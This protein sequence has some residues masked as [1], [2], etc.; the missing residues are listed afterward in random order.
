MLFNILAILFAIL[1]I[2]LY[3]ISYDDNCTGWYKP[4]LI[5]FFIL[6]L[7]FF[8]SGFNKERDVYT[9]WI[10]PSYILLLC[11]VIV[12]LQTIIN[13][14]LEYGLLHE[15][16]RASGYEAVFGKCLFIGVLSIVGF[17]IGNYNTHY[18]W[19]T[20]HR[21]ESKNT[22]QW[23][24]VLMVVMFVLFI[25]NIDVQAF[26]YG[27]VYGGSGSYNRVV[28]SYETY[29]NLL[30]SCCII[31][32]A[33]HSQI[34]KKQN[35]DISFIKYVASLPKTVLLVIS[36][37]MILRL[38]GGERGTIIF[39][40]SA[41][42]FSYYL[43]THKKIK[44]I[45]VVLGLAVGSFLLTILGY[46]RASASI[47]N[48][49]SFSER[50]TDATNLSEEAIGAPKSISRYTQEL[51]NSVNCNFIALAEKEKGAL[52]YKYGMYSAFQIITSAP[53]SWFLMS[54]LGIDPHKYMSAIYLTIAFFGPYYPYGL[55]VTPVAEAYLDF[56]LF[57]TFILFLLM[58][59]IYKKIELLL[60]RS[61]SLSIWWVIVIIQFS[62][63][64]IYVA[65]S[66]FADVFSSVIY[67]LIL[68]WVFNTI[69]SRFSS[70]SL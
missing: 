48:E 24:T 21:Q 56:G 47:G 59:I 61:Q 4:I 37:Y 1:N 18:P 7:I 31:I 32:Y 25:M 14:L 55:G 27:T 30:E 68:F 17:L 43:A 44:L 26:V 16:L 38:L 45:Y 6:L 62:S 3:T 70:R 53:G 34:I 13:V 50:F 58:G 40:L 52:E 60:V 9:F 42:L 11:L 64:S 10:R 12:N 2:C 49:T 67:T 19:K 46:T 69:F 20:T 33:L 66:S 65:R 5:V 39:N 41:L 63:V 22:I 51:A 28:Q 36:L 8:K 35:R 15:Y 29:A 57:G 54:Q 23:W